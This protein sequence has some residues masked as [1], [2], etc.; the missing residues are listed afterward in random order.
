MTSGSDERDERDSGV[1][2]GDAGRVD[3]KGASGVSRGFAPRIA[4]V[5]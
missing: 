3:G 5:T 4:P 2:E 1:G